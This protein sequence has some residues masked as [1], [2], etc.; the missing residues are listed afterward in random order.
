[1]RADW[2]LGAGNRSTDMKPLWPWGRLRRR[3][4]KIR[5]W[6]D[7]VMTRVH[8]ATG[9]LAEISQL[10]TSHEHQLCFSPTDLRSPFTALVAP[11]RLMLYLANG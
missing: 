8:Y 6:R 7:N 3:T 10:A 1:M 5:S 11:R 4:R 2:F 9:S